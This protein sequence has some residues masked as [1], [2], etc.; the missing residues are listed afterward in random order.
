MEFLLLLIIF[1]AWGAAWTI[2]YRAAGAHTKSGKVVRHLM[3]AVVGF[4][5]ATV[6]LA[7]VMPGEEGGMP[8]WPMLI[9]AGIVTGVLINTAR[10]MPAAA[11]RVAAESRA[12]TARRSVQDEIAALRSLGGKTRPMPAAAPVID[13]LDDFIDDDDDWESVGPALVQFDYR[14]ANGE[15]TTR[16][17]EVKQ[18]RW[19]KFR[20]FCHHARA[21][22][23]FRIDRIQGD[24]VDLETG[25]VLDP[26]A[27][28][29][30][31]EV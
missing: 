12:A 23:T 5:A 6:L 25:E 31:L 7:V 11:Q 27:W 19:D 30:A 1:G 20:G 16:Q 3:G 18:V 29:E 22:R 13:D 21:V 9:L 8:G 26:E 4:V 15:E 14:N 2:V 24:V 28:F 17:V 10:N